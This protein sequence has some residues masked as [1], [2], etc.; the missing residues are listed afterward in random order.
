MLSR[1]NEDHPSLQSI[2]P[3]KTYKVATNSFIGAH[4]VKAFGEGIT[5]NDLGVLIR[6]VLIEDIKEN[7]I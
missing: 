1:E 6:D 7:G 5:L 3:E 2:I 4:A